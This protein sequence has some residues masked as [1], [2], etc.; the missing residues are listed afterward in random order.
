[1]SSDVT[2]NGEVL[3]ANQERAIAALLS[4]PSIEAAATK[5]GVTGRTLLRWL[6]EPTFADA[7]REARHEA[8][9]HAIC[10]LQRASGAAVTTLLKIATDNLAPASARVSASYKILEY[11]FRG[12]EIDNMSARIESIERQLEADHKTKEKNP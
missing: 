9:Q 8:T 6:A 11:A 10:L 7:Y 4:S 2:Q 5:A 12:V 1:M 3:S